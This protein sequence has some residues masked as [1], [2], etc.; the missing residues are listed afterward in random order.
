M[1]FEVD[2]PT[3]PA[4]AAKLKGAQKILH[5][6]VSKSMKRLSIKGQ[7][8]SRELAPVDTSRLRNSI[9]PR[10]DDLGGTIHAIW[11]TNVA[12]GETLEEGR[13]ADKPM[14]PTGALL[15]WMHRHGIPIESEFALRRSIGKKGFKGHHFMKKGLEKVKPLVDKELSKALERTLKALGAD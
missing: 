11:G 3:L 9:V 14:P 6:E 5:S 13:G 12:Y 4:F 2:W 1:D 10:V 15:G 7:G 8:F